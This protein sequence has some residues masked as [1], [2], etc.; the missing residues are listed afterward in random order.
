MHSRPPATSATRRDE[1]PRRREPERGF[2]MPGDPAERG[3][4]HA[5]RGDRR[6]AVEP[7]RLREPHPG[8]GQVR[9]QPHRRL[10]VLDL[11][12]ARP[13]AEQ[14]T[15][16]GVEVPH[17]HARRRC[18]ACA[19][20]APRASSRARTRLDRA[21]SRPRGQARGQALGALTGSAYGAASSA[22]GRGRRQARRE[23]ENDDAERPAA[24]RSHTHP[25]RRST[26]PACISAGG[27]QA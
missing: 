16:G 9:R 10:R 7:E 14:G 15:G 17:A 6:F 20:P 8:R 5:Q 2:E 25:L 1:Q 22:S 13:R 23:P 3:E 4:R 24:A 26:G 11:L 12:P 18:G 27:R 21:R 19:R